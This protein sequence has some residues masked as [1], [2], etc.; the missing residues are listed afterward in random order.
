MDPALCRFRIGRGLLEA[1][2]GDDAALAALTPLTVPEGEKWNAAHV[3]RV[4]DAVILTVDRRG[5]GDALLGVISSSEGSKSWNGPSPYPGDG[6]ELVVFAV[7][8]IDGRFVLVEKHSAKLDW[9][10]GSASHYVIEEIGDETGSAFGVDEDDRIVPGEVPTL[11]VASPSQ[12]ELHRLEG[13]LTPVS[14]AVPDDVPSVEPGFRG[15][16]TAW[17]CSSEDGID[18]DGVYGSTSGRAARCSLAADGTLTSTYLSDDRSSRE[19]AVDLGEEALIAGGWI[20]EPALAEGE[21]AEEGV[22]TGV[23]ACLWASRDGG[24]RWRRTMLPDQ[25]RRERDR[26]LDRALGRE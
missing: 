17:L 8:D 23:G 3:A 1:W 4:G 10:E 5:T 11:G 13:G 2:C 26:A 7:H 24:E 14:G 21:E 19:R 20:N 12:I 18:G 6:I 16:R 9:E 22:E 15:L 25:A